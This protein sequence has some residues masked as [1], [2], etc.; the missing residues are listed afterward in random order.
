MFALRTQTE[1]EQNL[2]ASRDFVTCDIDR[3]TNYL[4]AQGH[5]QFGFLFVAFFVLLVDFFL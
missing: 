4:S 5:G 2:R 1:Y 3:E